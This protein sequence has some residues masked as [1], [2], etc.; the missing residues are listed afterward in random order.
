MIFGTCFDFGIR[1]TRLSSF[2]FCVSISFR[3]PARIQRSSAAS[4]FIAV[5]GRIRCFEWDFFYE[6]II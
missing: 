3:S 4:A 2:V 6:L 1:S 5:F